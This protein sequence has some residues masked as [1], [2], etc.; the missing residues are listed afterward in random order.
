MYYGTVWRATPTPPQP[1]KICCTILVTKTMFTGPL[2]CLVR[3]RAVKPD[4]TYDREFI[5]TY[6]RIQPVRKPDPDPTYK[7]KQMLT[8]NTL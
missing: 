1:A 7:K 4:M 5:S 6:I 2:L 3:R 8:L